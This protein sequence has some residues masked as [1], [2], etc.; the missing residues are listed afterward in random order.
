MAGSPLVQ[1]IEPRLSSHVVCPHCKKRQPF[2]KEKEHW[3]T[4]KAPHL[5]HP[6]VLRVR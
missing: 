1:V 6:V 2:I 5:R 3:R 4:V